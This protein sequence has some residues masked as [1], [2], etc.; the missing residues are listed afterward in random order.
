MQIFNS[1][2]CGSLIILGCS[3]NPDCKNFK[4]GRFK[5]IETA[6]NDSFLIERNDTMQ[7]EKDL[8]TGSITKFEVKWLT[9]CEYELI[10]L[11]GRK[12][13]M[14]FYE[15][16]VLDTKIIETFKDAYK[17]EATVK[18]IGFKYIGMMKKL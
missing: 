10:I 15:G 16:K 12:E 4:T 1:I 14:A 18:G 9:D 2:I 11:E 13:I 7:I 3:K 8:K 17:F 5:L 6:L